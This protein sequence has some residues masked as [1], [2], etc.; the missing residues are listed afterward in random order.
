M[1]LAVEDAN[2]KLVDVVAF[3]DADIEATAGPVS[4]SMTTVSQV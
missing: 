1:I 2:L 3:A 4:D